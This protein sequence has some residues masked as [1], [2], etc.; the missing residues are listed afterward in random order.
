MKEVM[1]MIVGMPL[2]ALLLISLLVA[3]TSATLADQGS[4]Y[5]THLKIHALRMTIN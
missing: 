4:L 5:V 2:L 3:A 1:T